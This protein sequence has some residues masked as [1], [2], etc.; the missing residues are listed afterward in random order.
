MS[1]DKHKRLVIEVAYLRL[2]TRDCGMATNIKWTRA[3]TR[4]LDKMAAR[5]LIV[6]R[7]VRHFARKT[8]TTAF[9]TPAGH[10]LLAASLRRFGD[11]FGP[12]SA[13]SRIE[14]ARGLRKPRPLLDPR[15][16]AA[17]LRLSARLAEIRAPRAI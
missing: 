8:V 17:S 12:V 9:A 4:L 3:R 11:D 2:A 6:F 14:P 10:E 16:A 7:T 13:I 1:A 15:R 5:G